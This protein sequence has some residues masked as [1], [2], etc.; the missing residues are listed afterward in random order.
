LSY[1]ILTLSHKI[2]LFSIFYFEKEKP[3]I[4]NLKG[5]LN[6]E[7]GVFFNSYRDLKNELPPI[8]LVLERRFMT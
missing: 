7:E 5:L 3:F 6:N 1:L 4:N 2:S 8:I